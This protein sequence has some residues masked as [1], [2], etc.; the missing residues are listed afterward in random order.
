MERRLWYIY[1]PLRLRCQCFSGVGF[2]VQPLDPTF[3]THEES[4]SHETF[5]VHPI[6]LSAPLEI[7]SDGTANCY[8][9]FEADDGSSGVGLLSTLL[10]MSLN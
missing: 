4:P 10:L 9:T 3:L 5:F 7:L 2:V 8:G 1:L 6:D